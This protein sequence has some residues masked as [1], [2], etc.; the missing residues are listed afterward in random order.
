MMVFSVLGY[1][2]NKFGYEAAGSHFV[3]GVLEKS[4]RQS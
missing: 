4:V 3:L 2:M 1:L